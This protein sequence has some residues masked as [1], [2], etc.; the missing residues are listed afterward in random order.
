MR[1]PGAIKPREKEG[2]YRSVETLR[3]P[4]SEF[5]SLLGARDKDLHWRLDPVD[6]RETGLVHSQAEMS[7]GI[8]VQQ[9]LIHRHVAESAD[10]LQLHLLVAH[11]DW[12]LLAALIA[13]LQKIIGVDVGDE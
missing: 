2:S 7:A 10:K 4:K 9:G 13:E 8:D 3:H 1:H 11:R 6:R 12:H 5:A